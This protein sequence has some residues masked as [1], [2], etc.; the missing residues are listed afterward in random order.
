MLAQTYPERCRMRRAVGD[1]VPSGA[2]LGDERAA[3]HIPR[4]GLA[5]R[6]AGRAGGRGA[7]R[8]GGLARR[9]A[10]GAGR[11]HGGVRGAAEDGGRRARRHGRAAP[12]P[13]GPADVPGQRQAGGAG[14][15]RGAREARPGG[16]RGR[17]QRRAAAPPGGPPEDPGGR[18]H[19]GDPR[20][21]RPARPHGRG[22]AAG[23]AGAARV[24]VLAPGGPVAAPGAPRRR[25]RHEGPRRD[26]ARVGPAAAAQ[27]HG[28]AAPAAEG[29]GPLAGDPARPPR[30]LRD[31]AAWR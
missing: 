16:R 10:R 28:D 12:R 18:P 13:A 11:P 3:A 25:R 2:S 31:P 17:P 15:D 20:H 8:G 1:L 22:Q 29:R 14:R 19:R 21:L 5:R 4:Q 26:P 24:L 7:R 6:P 23:R 30:R 27:P 9:R